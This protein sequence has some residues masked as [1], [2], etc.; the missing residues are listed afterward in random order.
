M[1][2]QLRLIGVRA[3]GN[4]GV[5]DFEREQGQEF[6]V[7]VVVDIDA[8]ASASSSDLD[9][10]VHYGVLAEEIVRDIENDPVDLIETLAERIAATVLSHPAALRTSVTVHKPQA[11]ITVPFADVSITIDRGRS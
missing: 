4:H 7:D 8:R 2:D 5:F 10:T 9:Q 11:P 1:V 3:T 6:V